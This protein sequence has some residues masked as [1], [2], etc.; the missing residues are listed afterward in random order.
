MWPPTDTTEVGWGGGRGR[1]AHLPA[2]LSLTCPWFGGV[3]RL[4]TALQSG[5]GVVWL[6]LGLC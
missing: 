2:C 3:G 6:L 5:E 4:V 1:D